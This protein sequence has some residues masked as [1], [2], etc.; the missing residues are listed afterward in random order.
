MMT[1]ELALMIY[2]VLVERLTIKAL[3]QHL[4][5]SLTQA[6]LDEAKHQLYV[7]VIKSQRGLQNGF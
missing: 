4:N 1:S 2:L 7:A 6:Q 5:E 3:E